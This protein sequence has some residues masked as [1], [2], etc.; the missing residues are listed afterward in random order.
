MPEK[1]IAN[2]VLLPELKL[3]RTQRIGIWKNVLTVERKK[4]GALCP[5]CETLSHSCYDHRWVQVKDAPLRDRHIDLRIR[6]RRFFCKPCRRVFTEKIPGVL[7]RR[8]TSERYRKNL[9]WACENF[10]NLKKVRQ[11]FRCSN[12]FLYRALHDQLNRKVLNNRYPWPSVIGLD[13]HSFQKRRTGNIPFA[14]MFVDYKNR[15]I[16]EVVG[17]KASEQLKEKLSEIPGRENVKDVVIDLADPYKKFVREFFPN[18]QMT[19]DKFHVLR[20]L[21]PAINRRRK[22]ITGDRRSLRIRR[23]LLMNASRL[24]YFQKA[25]ILDFLNDHPELKQI[26][27]T[28]EK[29]HALYRC[30]GINRAR[31][32]LHNLLKALKNTTVPELKTLRSTL[33]KWSQE[34]LNH[35]LNGLT[36]GRTEGFNTIAKLVKK[37]AFGYRNF[38]NY[39]RRLLCACF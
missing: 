3:L 31:L 9:L 13:E 2:F 26:W 38:E 4:K 19:A 18:A 5:H 30:K 7:A 8:R 29:M 39:R 23:L 6:K 16:F 17:S 11:V 20:L 12:D 35:F 27:I 36:N 34:I 22:E 37:R 33:W 24:D 10:S 28:K 15:K 14:S 32:A 21:H 25:E 1:R